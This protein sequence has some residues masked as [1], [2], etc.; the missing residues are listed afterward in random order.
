M[1][2]KHSKHLFTTAIVLMI[3]TF[4]AGVLLGYNLNNRQENEVNHII[5]ETELTTESYLIE[6]ELIDITDEQSC[7]L[8]NQRISDLSDEISNIGTRLNAPGAEEKLGKENFNFL[9]RK[10][11]LLQ[12]KAYLFYSRL[13]K[14]CSIDT[15]II[16]YYYSPDS[17]VDIGPVLSDIANKYN[18]RIFPVEF[19]FSEEIRFMESYYDISKTPAVIINYG[20]KI[21]DDI[22]E[23]SILEALNST[24]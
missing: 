10:Y 2:S 7:S 3:V 22:T 24:G 9:K 15:D 21:E 13:L 11:Y 6:Q 17:E 19:G 18:I 14:E 5:L 16:L 1:V 20:Q 8:T 4:V 23:G 12:I